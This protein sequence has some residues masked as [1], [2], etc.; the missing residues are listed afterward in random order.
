MIT[1][2]VSQI[3]VHLKHTL[4]ISSAADIHMEVFHAASSS[5][6]MRLP[7]VWAEEYGH[8]ANDISPRRHES[9][10]VI[11]VAVFMMFLIRVGTNKYMQNYS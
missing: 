6:A 8:K 1:Y 2:T 4:E 11:V 3:S 9:K 7:P 5:G 10:E